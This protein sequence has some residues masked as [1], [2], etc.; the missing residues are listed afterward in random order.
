MTIFRIMIQENMLSAPKIQF[1]T[2][3]DHGSQ[4]VTFNK[5][6][7]EVFEKKKTKQVTF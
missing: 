2:E 5:G 3:I 1:K 6:K 7:M 4:T